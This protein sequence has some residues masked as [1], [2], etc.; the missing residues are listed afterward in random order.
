MINL[1]FLFYKKSNVIFMVGKSKL[2]N[3]STKTLNTLTSFAPLKA[4]LFENVFGYKTLK[5]I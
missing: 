3:N 1:T 5:I 4:E 2:M